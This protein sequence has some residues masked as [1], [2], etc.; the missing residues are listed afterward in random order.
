MPKPEGLRPGR[1]GSPNCPPAR[2]S[3]KRCKLRRGV[4]SAAPA[5]K[6]F[7][8]LYRARRHMAFPDIS[9]ASD[10]AS[11]AKYLGTCKCLYPEQMSKYVA[12]GVNARML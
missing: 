3:E 4:R 6:R 11:A 8:A 9:K 1:E 12:K 2:G 10:H 5:A 7:L